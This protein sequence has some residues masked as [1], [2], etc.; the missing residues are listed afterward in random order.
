MYAGI[1]TNGASERFIIIIII[2]KVSLYRGT[3]VQ[4][5]HVCSGN[6]KVQECIEM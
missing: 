6:V 1:R 5:I 2:I 4:C 3:V